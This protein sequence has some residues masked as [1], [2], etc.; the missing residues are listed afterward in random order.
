MPIDRLGPSQGSREEGPGAADA[1]RACALDAGR[2]CAAAASGAAAAAAAAVVVAGPGRAEPGRLWCTSGCTVSA[3]HLLC[4]SA[5]LRAASK[6]TAASSTRVEVMGLLGSGTGAGAPSR[7]AVRCAPTFCWQGRGV[8]VRRALSVEL[9]SPN[10]RP[11]RTSV[12]LNIRVRARVGG[13]K[14]NSNA[15]EGELE[16]HNATPSRNVAASPREPDLDSSRARRD[17]APCPEW[18]G[19]GGLCRQEGEP[20]A[21][22]PQNAPRECFYPP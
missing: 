3:V 2:R 21:L 1:G 15:L 7:M 19:E 16:G 18:G 6:S 8:G 12:R 10:V 22:S 14:S 4:A 17:P 9:T 13:L 20:I 11:T 5:L